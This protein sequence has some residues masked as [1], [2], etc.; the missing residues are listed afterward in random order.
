MLISSIIILITLS[1]ILIIKYPDSAFIIG[2]ISIYIILFLA[3][4]F[5]GSSRLN[6]ITGS[7]QEN[8]VINSLLLNF[9]LLFLI[10][11]F[12]AS[13]TNQIAQEQVAIENRESAPSLAL[14]YEANDGYSITN[15]KGIASYV[16]FNAYDQYNFIHNG[17]GY[18]IRIGSFYHEKD[19]RMNLDASCS[20]LTFLP[21]QKSYR[22]KDAYE[23]LTGYVNEKTGSEITPTYS[24][25]LSLEFFDYQNE[26]RV[27]EYNEYD[28]KISLA[29]TSGSYAPDH[30]ITI[31]AY[32]EFPLEDQIKSAVDTLL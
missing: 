16:Q 28:R 25:M 4:N 7:I 32:D 2:I 15:D 26:H 10:G 12:I 18:Q 6:K 8:G 23:I 17:E 19:N 29:S 20:D 30:N 3:I 1:I 11:T 24:H 14:S 21:S 5:S 31:Y 22:S 27:F 9:F 13:Q